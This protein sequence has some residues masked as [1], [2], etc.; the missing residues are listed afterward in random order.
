[1][2]ATNEPTNQVVRTSIVLFLVASLVHIVL[3]HVAYFILVDTF[4]FPE[5]LRAPTVDMLAAYTRQ[6]DINR[7]AYYVFTLTGF[8]F[9]L[10][11]LFL[12]SGFENRGPLAEVGRTF[13]VLAGLLQAL[14]FGRWV[15]LVPWI[16]DV[17][18]TNDPEQQSA[19]LLL[20]AFHR[21]AGILAGE[22]LAFVAHGIA[23]AAFSVHMLGE[24]RIAPVFAYLGIPIHALIGLYSLEQFGGSLAILGPANVVF[25][26]L[27]LAWLL[28]TA[29]YLYRSRGNNTAIP[30]PLG[31]SLMSV[32]LAVMLFAALA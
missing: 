7:F 13:A 26:V 3:M 20:E 18:Q 10:M 25:Q 17:V 9:I 5:I 19:L 1:M 14:G 2:N 4:Q 6:L 30:G 24:K 12:Y 16:A 29:I 32:T 11:H 15:F 21:Y 22:N 28:F 27:W 31:Y 23:G 8:T